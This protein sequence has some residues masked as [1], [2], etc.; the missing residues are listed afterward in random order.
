MTSIRWISATAVGLAERRTG[1]EARSRTNGL[2]F[3]G[4]LCCLA[5]T[6]LL[7]LTACASGGPKR[8]SGDRFDYNE[9]I[10]RSS[11]EQMLANIVRFR[12]LDFPVFMAVSSVITSYAYEG[13]VGVE[14]TAGLSEVA[15]G[16]SVTG[17]VNLAY[18][19]RP[20]VTYAPLSGQEFTRRML[21]PISVQ[22]IFALGQ[23][24]WDIEML[25]L[26][27]INRINDVENLSFEVAPT[28]GD[29]DKEQ[30]LRQ[31][32]E[33]IR[34]FQRVVELLLNL[35]EQDVIELQ[36]PEGESGLPN[37]VFDYD[38]PREFQPAVGELRT[39]LALDPKR[40][41]FSVTTR[42]AQR[43]ADEITIHS[44][45]LLAI[46]S[47]LAKGV[48]IP[49]VHLADGWAEPY[50]APPDASVTPYIP[51][52]IR[53]RPERPGSAFAAV[54]YQGYWFYV[55]QADLSSKAM[56]QMLL[57]LFELQAPA[58]GTAA[59]LLTLPAGG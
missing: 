4:L 38:V 34:R 32:I 42:L 33:N 2:T 35:T 19:E 46:M 16:D 14:G 54:R 11:K 28:T 7:S 10:S 55:D 22:A 48:E 15:G 1:S 3:R 59:P 13:G 44:R 56:F 45:S 9:A 17:S 57:A 47:F 36:R 20:T 6:V 27:G 8:L 31:D 30:Q 25:L 52:R 12:Y 18:S 37:L 49:K 24:G 58:G 26:T 29:V 51:L 50:Q 21:A 53:S 41:V 39:L 23:T 40:D 5:T 43:K